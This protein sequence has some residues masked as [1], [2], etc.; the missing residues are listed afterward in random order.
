MAGL[1]CVPNL[2]RCNSGQV[3]NQTA[4]DMGQTRAKPQH[5][6]LEFIETPPEISGGM[7]V[8]IKRE[9]EPVPEPRFR[10]ANVK[11]GVFSFRIMGLGS[12]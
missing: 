11:I 10:V 7:P 9:R 2:L 3:A 1:F 4:P 8:P 5:Y 6:K 12:V